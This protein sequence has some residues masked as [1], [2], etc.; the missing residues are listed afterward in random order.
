MKSKI[1][2][3]KKFKVLSVGIVFLVIGVVLGI[4]QGISL[5]LAAK[6]TLMENPSLEY[7]SFN[8]DSIY[9]NPQAILGLGLIKL[10]YWNILVMPIAL[11]VM[12]FLGG[13]LISFLYN[14]TAKYFGGIK[15]VLD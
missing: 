4:F 13:L 15:I 1:S 2:E 10:G 11:G 3:I 14:L 9:G 5:G 7:T 8:D 6:Q 12:Y